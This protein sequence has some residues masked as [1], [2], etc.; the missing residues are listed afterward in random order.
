LFDGRRAIRSPSPVIARSEV[1]LQARAVLPRGAIDDSARGARGILHLHGDIGLVEY[2]G[3]EAL[4]PEMLV[5]AEGQAGIRDGACWDQ[6]CYVREGRRVLLADVRELQPRR[7][8]LTADREVVLDPAGEGDI[9]REGQR[10]S[11]RDQRVQVGEVAGE[12][13]SSPN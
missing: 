10:R 5:R 9:G 8:R 7:Q 1:V 13:V 12:N 3:D 6:R 11:L 2:V 4:Q